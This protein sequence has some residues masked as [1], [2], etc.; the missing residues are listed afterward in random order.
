MNEKK[1]K[2]GFSVL[3]IVMGVI[4]FMSSFIMLADKEIGSY[5]FLAMI[6]GLI[7]WI[8]GAYALYIRRKSKENNALDFKNIKLINTI[9]FVISV[10]ILATV[11]ILPIIAPLL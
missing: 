3:N 8:V 7:L 1:I 2:T 4:L 9:C 5:G 10:L 6:L 11:V